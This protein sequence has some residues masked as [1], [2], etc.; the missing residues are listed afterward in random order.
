[1]VKTEEIDFSY[2]CSKT[3]DMSGLPIRVY[4]DRYLDAV[5]SV[6]P[7]VADPVKKYEDA[8]LRGDERISYFI[9]ENMDYYG[10]LRTGNKTILIGPSRT[11]PYTAQEIRDLAFDLGVQSRDFHA[12]DLSMRSI[13]PMPLGTILQMMLTLNYSLNGE[14]LDLSDVGYE[15]SDTSARLTF[16]DA[17]GTS[18]YYKNY[19][20]EQNILKLVR[21]GDV[22]ALRSWAKSAPTVR[23]SM[24]APN[25][26]RQEKNTFIASV[27]LVSRAAIEEGVDAK[28]AIKESD[29]FIQRCENAHDITE[30]RRLQFEM[31]SAFTA[32][33][34]RLK[35]NT[36]GSHLVHD[37]YTYITGH[38]SEPIRVEEIAEAMYMSRS[39]LSTS[40]R[41]KTGMTVNEYIHRLK[42]DKAKEL[43][44]DRTKSIALISDYLGYSSSSH[45]NRM[46]KKFT[47]VSPFT[48]RK[49]I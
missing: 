14:K 20:V 24:K 48:Y 27:T 33:V 7:L 6:A 26:L 49:N 11:V 15:G 18:D 8:L 36:D 45:F 30:L 44:Q 37:A 32:E 5:F 12:F 41:K 46:F 47:S 40:F 9:A 43:L 22:S 2:I 17:V 38:I 4:T 35:D 21:K 34:G 16:E 28:T 1:M 29:S 42:I 31:V 13:L 3:S 23:S 25:Y 19:N 10:V 39:H